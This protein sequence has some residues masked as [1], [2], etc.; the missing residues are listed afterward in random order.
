MHWIVHHKA[1]PSVKSHDFTDETVKITVSSVK[2]CLLT[3]D[4]KNLVL[5]AHSGVTTIL[6]TPK[7]K[8]QIFNFQGFT[9]SCTLKTTFSRINLWKI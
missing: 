7:E 2:T 3:D 9:I 6:Q 1:W 8:S 5:I 4:L